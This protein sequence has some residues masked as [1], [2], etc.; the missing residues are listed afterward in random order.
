MFSYKYLA[1]NGAL[2]MGIILIA[3]NKPMDSRHRCYK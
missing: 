1:S 3:N 2:I